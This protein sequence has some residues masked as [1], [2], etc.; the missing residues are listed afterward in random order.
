MLKIKVS[1]AGRAEIKKEMQDIEKT[2]N[3]IEKSRPVRNL[4]ASLDK[5][6]HSQEM[7]IALITD[8]L[9]VFQVYS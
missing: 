8:R 3:T 6:G 4:G 1:K 2:W 9:T 5:W 7:K